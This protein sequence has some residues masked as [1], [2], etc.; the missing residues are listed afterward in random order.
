MGP[1]LRQPACRRR[2]QPCARAA[3]P[4]GGRRRTSFMIRIS[5]S[6]STLAPDAT[7]ASCTHAARLRLRRRR[8]G[9][10]SGQRGAGARTGG[11]ASSSSQS[12][13]PPLSASMA[14]NSSCRK[15]TASSAPNTEQR[16]RSARK[17]LG[18]YFQA[19]PVFLVLLLVRCQ[20][21]LRLLVLLLRLLAPLASLVHHAHA[22]QRPC[23][24]G[25][26]RARG[27]RPQLPSKSQRKSPAAVNLARRR[28]ARME[29]TPAAAA[30]RPCVGHAP[31]STTTN[32]GFSAL[33]WSC[34][35]AARL[36]TFM[37]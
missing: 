29:A 4:R 36:F 9:G 21:S 14:A 19:R 30:C 13:V 35:L 25:G 26:E 15:T 33:M 31:L 1:S 7:S 27:R 34:S 2:P 22:A 6:W 17:R 11:R 24:R 28:A 18:L 16:L 37:M 3:Q 8:R 10:R 32:S 5:S 12:I 20:L 23:V